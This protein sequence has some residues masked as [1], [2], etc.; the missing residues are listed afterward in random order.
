MA[1]GTVAGRE[2]QMRLKLEGGDAHGTRRTGG[3]YGVFDETGTRCPERDA[4]VGD[5]ANVNG[6]GR[7]FIQRLEQFQMAGKMPTPRPI[8]SIDERS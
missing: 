3:E 5:D 2:A 4:L 8:S 6:S 7:A 1:A